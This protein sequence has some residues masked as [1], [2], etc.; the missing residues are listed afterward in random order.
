MTTITTFRPRTGRM[1]ELVLLLFAVGIVL[2]AYVNVGLAV[3]GEIPPKLQLHGGLLLGFTLALHLVLR[4]RAKYADP[5]LLPIATLLNG[6][7]LVMIVTGAVLVG[8][9]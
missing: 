2:L 3:K 9:I 8:I 6:L 1:T 4:W 7:G 5:L